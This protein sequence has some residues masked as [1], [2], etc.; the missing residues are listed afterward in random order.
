M[1]DERTSIEIDLQVASYDMLS[2][3]GGFPR[4]TFPSYSA[5]QYLQKN[6]NYNTPF[7][8]LRWTEKGAWEISDWHTLYSNG[9]QYRKLK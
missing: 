7:I 9:I 1:E 2:Y 6:H 8:Y 5:A 4:T 3:G